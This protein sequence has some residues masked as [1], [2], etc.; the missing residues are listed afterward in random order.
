MSAELERLQG[1]YESV[2]VAY[3]DCGTYGAL[4]AAL[5]GTGVSRIAAE[6]CYDMFA[7]DEVARRS[8]R[9]PARTS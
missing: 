9:S 1:D 6:H 5:A 3:G 4:D 7:R 2:A 8:P